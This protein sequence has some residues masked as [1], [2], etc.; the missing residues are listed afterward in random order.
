M[1]A[2]ERLPL[3]K[4]AERVP[5]HVPG[6]QPAYFRIFLCCVALSA[7]AATTARLFPRGVTGR[8]S[9]ETELSRSVVTGLIL[10]DEEDGR[11]LAPG[12]QRNAT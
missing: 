6:R 10:T 7:V 4:E 12:A 2:A 5:A 1:A 3:L 8:P 9:Q 11:T